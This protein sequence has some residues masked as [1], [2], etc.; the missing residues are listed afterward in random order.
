M[1][2][3]GNIEVKDQ[4]TNTKYGL[5]PKFS[6]FITNNVMLMGD[7]TWQGDINYSR[8]MISKV[9]VAA[10][11]YKSIKKRFFYLSRSKCDLFFWHKLLFK[12]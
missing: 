3:F 6:Q 4:R 7:L 12:P 2:W 11:Y 1:A 9:T 8:E 5:A 10:R